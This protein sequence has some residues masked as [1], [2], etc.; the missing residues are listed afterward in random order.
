MTDNAEE[1]TESGP[2][3]NQPT[4]VNMY[5]LGGRVYPARSQPQCNTCQSEYRLEIEQ[6][7]LRGYGYTAIARSLPDDAG[8]SMSSIRNHVHNG[9]L[10]L[11]ESVK[12]AAVEARA[13]EL[14]RDIENYEQSLVDHIT[15]AKVGIQKAFQKMADGE[16]EVT[17]QDGIA[18][19]N[20]LAKVEQTAS[21]SL[22][23]DLVYEVFAAYMRAFVA[24]EPTS[25]K[26][27]Q[28]ANALRRDPI[29]QSLLNRWSAGELESGDLG[30]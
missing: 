21:E 5:E 16:E 22:D 7:L 20:L 13:Q 12:R 30:S 19:A 28:F 27:R 18:F 10:P 4:S 14:G 24:T 17:I 26:Q 25:D 8:I 23:T 6:K 15:F 29:L 9:H 2:T 3:R 11:D 1:V